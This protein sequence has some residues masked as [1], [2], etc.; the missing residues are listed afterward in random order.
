MPP[1]RLQK[2]LAGAGVASRRESER[3]IEAGRVTVDGRVANVGDQVDVAAVTIAVDG[4]PI[5][6]ASTPTYLL[7]HKPLD[8][9]STVRDRHADRTVIDAVPPEYRPPGVRLFPVGRL[10][11]DSEGLIILTNDGDWADRVIHP[12]QG[13]ER[14][15]A[16][17]L[18][19]PLTGDQI[20]RLERGIRLE[21]GLALIGGLRSATDTE[22]RRLSRLL[23]PPTG[24]G[25]AWYRTTLRQGWKRQLRRMFGAIGAPVARLVRVRIG[26]VRLGDLRSGDVR[27]L[28]P[29][30][31]RRLGMGGARR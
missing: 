16:I 24:P 9:V 7:L 22:S 19:A 18:R 10:D 11:R 25:L 5:G 30:E 17:A 13:V 29:D 26:T 1:E 23:T 28:A 6:P 31:V 12:R 15:Y 27:P 4:R 3:L 21:E 8:V 2:I 14:E 20:G